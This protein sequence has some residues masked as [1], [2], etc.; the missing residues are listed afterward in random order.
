MLFCIGFGADA[1]RRHGG[2]SPEKFHREMREFKIKFLAQEME[3]REDQVKSFADL[4]NKMSDERHAALE[5]GRKAEERLR[6]LQNPTEADYRAASDAI[7][8]ARDKEA[9]IRQ[10]Y[11]AK[12]KKLLTPKQMFKMKEA[13][14]KF[15]GRLRDMREQNCRSPK[16]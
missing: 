14:R 16:R 13:E 5:A 2:G 11:E 8:A 15:R 3:L 7:S 10:K 1:Q 9:G 6:G 12:F 4:Y